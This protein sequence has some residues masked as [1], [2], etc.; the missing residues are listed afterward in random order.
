MKY[1][2]E[3]LEAQ[4]KIIDYKVRDQKLMRRD[5]KMA[6]AELSKITEIKKAIKILKSKTN[7]HRY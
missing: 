7:K 6:V 3:L 5:M 1:V 2:I 4:K